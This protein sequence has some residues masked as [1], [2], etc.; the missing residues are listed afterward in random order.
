[1]I[2]LSLSVRF[3]SYYERI[4]TAFQRLIAKNET[5]HRCFFPNTLQSIRNYRVISKWNRENG[6]IFIF[7]TDIAPVDGSIVVGIFMSHPICISN[8]VHCACMTAC[9]TILNEVQKQW[10]YRV[11]G[12][13]EYYCISCWLLHC[14]LICAPYSAAAVVRTRNME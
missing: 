4:H 1:M 7:S 2:C 10:K 12:C 3:P 13:N 8:Y 5:P 14:W 6:E 9:C 11:Y